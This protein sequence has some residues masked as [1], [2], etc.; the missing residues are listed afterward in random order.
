[1][2]PSAPGFAIGTF[3]RVR[4]EDSLQLQ[5]LRTK[6]CVALTE[7]IH[8]FFL[9]RSRIRQNPCLLFADLFYIGTNMASKSIYSCN[10]WSAAWEKSQRICCCSR[11]SLRLVLQRCA[12]PS[13]SLKVVGW[14]PMQQLGFTPGSY[15]QLQLRPMI[16]GGLLAGESRMGLV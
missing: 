7:K 9:F 4:L 6:S 16:L 8:H 11:T 10:S 14:P 13:V 15:A 3:V 2:S 12:G 5:L 1:M